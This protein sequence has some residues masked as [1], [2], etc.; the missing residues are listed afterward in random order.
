M[1][2][3]QVAQVGIGF[4]DTVMAGG[5]GKEDFGRSGFG[6]QRVFHDLH[7]LYGRNGG[8]EPDDCPVVRRR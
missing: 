8:I 6:Q 7:Y 3:A 1:L 2:L 4:V 5:A